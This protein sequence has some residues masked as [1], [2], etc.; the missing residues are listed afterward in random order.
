VGRF[1]KVEPRIVK[2]T[3]GSL[4]FEILLKVGTAIAA[5]TIYKVFLE[6]FAKDIGNKI[7]QSICSIFTKPKRKE[8]NEIIIDIRKGAK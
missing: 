7:K 3:E 2:I 4:I 8:I 6:D 5:H 1:H